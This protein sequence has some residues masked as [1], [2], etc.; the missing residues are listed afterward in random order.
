VRDHHGAIDV[1]FFLMWSN[2]TIFVTGLTAGSRGSNVEAMLYACHLGASS[3][4]ETEEEA[5]KVIILCGQYNS[6]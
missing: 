1:E 6:S 3:G 5:W 2:A 4:H